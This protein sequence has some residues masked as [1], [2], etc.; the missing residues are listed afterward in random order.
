MSNKSNNNSH[1][2]HTVID[3][4]NISDDKKTEVLK[5]IFGR[6]TIKIKLLE[7]KLSYEMYLRYGVCKNIYLD[8]YI[9][10]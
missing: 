4:F 7:Q 8:Y 6:D 10:L 9:N 1:N 3:N 2:T 5:Y